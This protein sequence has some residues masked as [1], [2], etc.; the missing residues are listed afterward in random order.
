VLVFEFWETWWERSIRHIFDYLKPAYT[1]IRLED[2][3]NV[4]DFYYYHHRREGIAD[5][6]C[7]PRAGAGAWN[8]LLDP[9]KLFG[10]A[11]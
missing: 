10:R 9:R 4:D 8:D 7:L 3:V 2:G 11:A 5:I 6:G 1:L